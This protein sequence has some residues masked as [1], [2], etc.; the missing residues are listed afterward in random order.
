MTDETTILVNG[1]GRPEGAPTPL[2]TLCAE[3][4][5]LAPVQDTPQSS[6]A[7]TWATEHLLRPGGADVLHLLVVVP[8]MHPSSAMAYG[9]PMVWMEDLSVYAAPNPPA[10]LPAR[11]SARHLSLLRCPFFLSSPPVAPHPP[12]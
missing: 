2:E 4:I 1:A 7:V 9:G 10:S 8:A 6:A 12:L 3:R 11:P 5:V